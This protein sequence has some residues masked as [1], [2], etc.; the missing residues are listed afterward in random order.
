MRYPCSGRHHG[1]A[2]IAGVLLLSASSWAHAATFVVTK[3]ADTNDGTCDSDCSLREAIIA[4]NANPGADVITL[5]AGTYT[6]TIPGA[7]E[8][9]GA[10]GDLDILGDLTIN[11]AGASTTIVNGGGLDRVSTSC[12]PSP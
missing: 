9:G 7:G 10:T 2:V 11:G 6:L 4:A 1:L 3:T 12:P 5:P 8:D